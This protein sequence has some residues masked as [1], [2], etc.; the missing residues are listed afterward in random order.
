LPP[1]ALELGT[2]PT[3]KGIQRES[4]ASIFD[5]GYGYNLTVGHA[6]VIHDANTIEGTNVFLGAYSRK[7]TCGL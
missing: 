7:H 6:L 1:L 3:T 2:T 5:Q 4:F